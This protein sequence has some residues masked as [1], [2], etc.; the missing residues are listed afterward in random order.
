MP[1]ASDGR[2]EAPAFQRNHEAVW[3]AISGFLI[4]R[5]GDMLELGKGNGLTLDEIV[6]MPA[7]NLVLVFVRA[8]R[9]N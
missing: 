7:N 1:P 9:Q 4:E 3:G 2:L 5:A 8:G 6:P